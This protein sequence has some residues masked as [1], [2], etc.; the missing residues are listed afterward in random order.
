MPSPNLNTTAPID[1]EQLVTTLL[2]K[3][4]YA[5]CWAYPKYKDRIRRDEL[6]DLSQQIFLLL[7]D[8][9]C[10]WLL[11]FDGQSSFNTW[12][13][14][15]VNHYIYRYFSNQKEIES[16]DVIDE[17]SLIYSPL[18]D[19]VIVTTERR[20]L[21]S[22]AL[23][24]LSQEERLL[25]QLWFIAEL[26]PREIAAIFGTEVK[27]IYKRKQTLFLKLVRLVRNSYSQ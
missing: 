17:G 21:L 25:Y 4:N 9:S 26:D 1:L 19:Q 2:P 3:I 15:V 27:I 24:K 7:I 5:L 16:L 6:D 12:L 13:Q 10:R 8:N 23:N 22:N 20:Q 18:L 14:A 11:S